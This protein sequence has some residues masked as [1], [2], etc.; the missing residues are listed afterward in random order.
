MDQYAPLTDRQKQLLEA[1]DI[2][3]DA[4]TTWEKYYKALKRYYAEMHDTNPPTTFFWG[5]L[6]LGYWVGAVRKG[7]IKLTDEQKKLLEELKFDWNYRSIQGTS[8]PEQ[9][10]LYYFNIWF[11]AENRKRLDG[12]EFDI[13]MEIGK[14]KIAVE[15]DGVAWHRGAKKL[16]NDNK[17][18]KYCKDNHIKLIRIREEGL[19]ITKSAIN[20][21]FP[22][23]F[24][25]EDFDEVLR[26]IFRE[27]LGNPLITIDTRDQ[28]LKILK[29]YRKL[30][31]IVINRHIKELKEYKEKYKSFPPS[32][33]KHNGL[34]GVMLYLR[35]IRKG[36]SH[37]LLTRENIAELDS[38]GFIWEP[39]NV[40]WENGYNHALEYYESHNH[41]LDVQNKYVS[42]DGY[43]LGN[44]LFNQRQRGP[45]GKTYRGTKL[46]EEQINKLNA[47]AMIW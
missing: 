37:G 10:T 15:Y 32:N 23:P 30:E 29:G 17:K 28:G 9:A 12:I 40:A 36:Q 33:K 14:E 5:P 19:P 13:Y 4:S 47:I 42:P 16:E 35:R 18:D 24:A 3:W 22:K 44:W 27:Q 6:N 21:V 43:K 31:D 34:Y 8:F 7:K 38:I 11:D 1:I 26:R 46:T 25:I 39:N 41:R 45:H 2:V 20:Y